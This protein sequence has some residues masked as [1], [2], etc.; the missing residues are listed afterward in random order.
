[1]E[2]VGRNDPCPC[3]SGKKFKKCC[4]GKAQPP[5]RESTPEEFLALVD[6]LGGGDIP[7]IVLSLDGSPVDDD[8]DGEDDC[9]ICVGMRERRQK[10]AAAAKER[11]R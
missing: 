7:Q 8:R 11:V 3:G 9:P 6:R 5:L 10:A 1:M 4:S 2:K